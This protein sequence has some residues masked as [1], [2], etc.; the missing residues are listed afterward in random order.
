MSEYK[1][2]E[3]IAVSENGFMFI[4]NTG[5]SFMVNKTGRFIINK[6]KEG[7]S[8]QEIIEMMIDEYDVDFETAQRDFD[9]F[10]T[11]LSNLKL[12]EEL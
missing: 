12:V 7:K 8:D 3:T 9:E 11:M 2:P 1:I 4:P 5:E 6:L 10:I